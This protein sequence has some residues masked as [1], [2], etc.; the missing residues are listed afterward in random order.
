MLETRFK[1]IF[2]IW[3][4]FQNIIKDNDIKLF[5]FIKCVREVSPANWQVTVNACIINILIR[6]Y[7]KN[8]KIFFGRFQE[9]SMC[10]AHLKQGATIGL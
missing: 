10:A 6:L 4:V 5:T 7:P 3:E 8:F 9:P 2:Y 1:G